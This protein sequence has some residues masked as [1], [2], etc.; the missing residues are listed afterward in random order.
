MQAL[1]RRLTTIPAVLL[2]VPLWFVLSPLVVPIIVL[3]DVMT[4]RFDLPLVRLWAFALVFCFHEWIGISYAA[5]LWTTGGFGRRM[6]N[7]AHVWM[8]GWWSTS[9]LGWADR[10]LSV[11]IDA[12]G[13]PLPEG[14]VIMLSR[15]AS[16]V[17]AIIPAHLF[18]TRFER[19]VH[20]VMKKELLQVPNIDIY[21]HRLGNH[22]VDRTG[23][24]D[25]EVA[26]I[27]DLAAQAHPDAGLVIFPEGTYATPNTKRRVSESL[28]RRG[29]D[30]ALR[31]NEQLTHLL[32]PKPAG[33]LALLAN[34][35]DSPIVI[36]AHTGLEGVAELSGLRRHL[37]LHH[38]VIVRWWEVD[39]S[40]VPTDPADQV[41]WL[42][43]QWLALDEWVSEHRAR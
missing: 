31:L 20:Y 42:N 43:G 13:V 26:Q 6:R 33:T 30:T 40:T 8:Q 23:D 7:D 29:D 2:A 21:G 3:F 11:H 39:R 27:A 28:A 41:D 14:N 12:D 16:M 10:L 22:F 4:G 5:W 15:H 24:T 18:P 37:P 38:P 19:P 9:L 32:P 35:P 34:C 25:A 17:D 1:K 36:L